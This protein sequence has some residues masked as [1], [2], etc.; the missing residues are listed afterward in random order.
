[1]P[2]EF[3]SPVLGKLPGGNARTNSEV[4]AN[5]YRKLKRNAGN[6]MCVALNK[7]KTY[8]KLKM[9]ARKSNWK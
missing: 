3:N 2:T 5:T 1:M 7:V 9:K 6:E 4:P 8:T